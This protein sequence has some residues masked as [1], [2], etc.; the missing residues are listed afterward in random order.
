[1]DANDLSKIA[2][3]ALANICNH[4]IILERDHNRHAINELLHSNL[5]IIHNGVVSPTSRGISTWLFGMED[6]GIDVVRDKLTECSELYATEYKEDKW[7]NIFHH[8]SCDSCENEACD[9]AKKHLSD[10][11]EHIDDMQK[12]II[13]H[14]LKEFNDDIELAGGFT[15]KDFLGNIRKTSTVPIPS[16]EA[17]KFTK[18]EQEI[19]YALYDAIEV[20]P[21]FS[22]KPRVLNRLCKDGYVERFDNKP[23]IID[24]RPLVDMSPFGTNRND[25]TVNTEPGDF[26]SLTAKGV[27]WVLFGDVESVKIFHEECEC[28]SKSFEWYPTNVVLGLL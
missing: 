21:S 8:D 19:L 5:I 24:T 18:S 4:K 13:S 22:F 2:R 6:I 9:H 15:Y 11:A 10:V 14:A 7:V 25:F 26:V 1:M 16:R 12:D 28:E 27:A 20:A 23:I 17:R 3:E